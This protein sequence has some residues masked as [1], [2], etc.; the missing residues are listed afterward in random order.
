MCVSLLSLS[1]HKLRVRLS[2]C[3]RAR[4]CVCVCICV[5][6]YVCLCVCVCLSVC[7]T[8]QWSLVCDKSGLT[9]LS[10]TVIMIGMAIG[11]LFF[12]SLSDRFG[13]KKVYVA[14]AFGLLLTTA[15][16]SFAPIYYVLMMFRVVT[17]ALIQVS[18]YFIIIIIISIIINPL[19]AR[20]VGAPQMILQPVFFNFPCSPLLTGT[21]RSPGLSI[22]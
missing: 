2:V 7:V 17:G 11:A 3:V 14:S 19:T 1:V 21:C 5:Y 4:L 12:G 9:E 22:P 20:V 15:A 13:R 6:V 10:Q 8:P 16:S 18:T